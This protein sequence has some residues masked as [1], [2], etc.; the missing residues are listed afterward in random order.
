MDAIH[1]GTVVFPHEPLVRVHGPLWQCQLLETPLLNIVNF[2]TL[3]AT[4]ASRICQATQGEPVLEFGLRRSQGID[5][6]LAASRAAYVGGCSA[7]SNLLA[8]KVYGIPVKGT[9]AHSWVMAFEDEQT[10]FQ[11]YADALPNNCV[12]LVDTY[13]TLAG[14]R[15]AIAVGLELQKRNH[16]FLGIRLDS[17]DLAEL[18]KSARQML[19]EAGLSEAAIVAS[20]DLDEHEIGELKRRGATINV[21]GVGT[22]LVTAYDQPALGGVYKLSALRNEQ[23]EWVNKLKLSEQEL[24]VSNP[25]IQQ[26]RRYRI[27]DRFCVDMIY[28]ERFGTKSTPIAVQVDSE[29]TVSPPVSAE[30]EELLVPVFRD[31]QL[32]AE[33]PSIHVARQRTQRQLGLLS[34]QHVGH[35]SARPYPVGL[36]EQL[37]RAKRDLIAAQRESV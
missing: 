19:D 24:K 5:G 11:A 34:E 3:I 6:G 29:V 12:F 9:H 8:G 14:V 10:S 4:K 31:G 32:V 7:T 15:R 27:P 18:S 22:R 25:G 16:R 20:N 13:N 36:E 30:T 2:Q 37:H 17:G 35:D 26:V 33:M 28:D 21:W 1:E 23:G